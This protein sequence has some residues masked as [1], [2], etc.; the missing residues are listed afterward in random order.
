MHRGKN[1][2]SKQEVREF[3]WN[4]LK[5]KGISR[6][7]G[8]IPNFFNSFKA[9][10]KLKL[11]KEF[12]DADVVFSAPDGV[13]RRARE[14]VLESEKELV[15]AT[16]HMKEFRILKNIPRN[17]IKKACTIRG[18]FTYGKRFE[19]D[20]EIDLFLTGCVAVDVKGNRVGKGSGY[21]DKEYALLRE[22]GLIK[23]CAVVAVCHD[24]QIFD[25]ISHLCEEHDVRSD[26]ILTPTRVI[27]I[28]K[29]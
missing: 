21:G 26:Y 3:V 24:L 12:K 14:I 2:K 22:R 9:C 7:Y 6:N 17:S 28:K 23:D 11:L 1:F 8:K 19:F 25:D 15:V 20:R 13:L 18:F 27:K 5:E 16:P 10:E 29:K 4:I